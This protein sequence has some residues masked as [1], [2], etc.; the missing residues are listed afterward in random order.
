MDENK[1]RNELIVQLSKEQRLSYGVIAEMFGI[2]RNAVAGVIF[3]HRYPH[4]I[5]IA[6]SDA[7]NRNKVGHGWRAASYQPEKTTVN[8]R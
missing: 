6:S 3:R 2:T 1:E 8:T 4:K 7:G 5:R